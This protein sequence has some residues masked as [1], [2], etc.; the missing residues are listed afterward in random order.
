M[1]ILFGIFN[2]L[3]TRRLK[4]CVWENSKV[5]PTEESV[6]DNDAKIKLEHKLYLLTQAICNS[7][8]LTNENIEFI[9]TLDKDKLIELVKLYNIVIISLTDFIKNNLNN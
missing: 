9:K 5:K 3:I 4:F 7:Q 1:W 8:T 2:Y 6:I